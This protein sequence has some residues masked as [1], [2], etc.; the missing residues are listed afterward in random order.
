[1]TCTTA[2]APRSLGDWL[3]YQQQVH[4]AGIALGLERVAAVAARLGLDRPA[5][6]VITVAGTNGKGSTVAFIDAIARAAGY[7]VGAYTSPHL[8]RYNERIRIDGVE[9]DDATLIAAFETIEA[10]RGDTPLTYF[11]FG[12]LAALLLFERAGLDLAVLEVGL[13]GRLDAVNL[14]DADVAVVTTVALDH[15][16]WLG[17]DRESIGREKAGVFRPQRPAVIG[18]PVAPASVREHAARIAARPWQIGADFHCEPRFGGGFRYREGTLT[19]DLPA[20][21]LAARCQPGNACTAIAALRQLGDALP[22]ADAAWPVGVAGA[23]VAGRTQRVVHAG[24]EYVLD[25]AHNPQAAQQLAGWLR[26]EPSRGATQAVFAALA[27]KDIPHLVAAMQGAV[28]AWRLAGLAEVGRRGLAA[29][30]LWQ[31]VAGL[32]ARCL[33]SRHGSVTEA[34][35]HAEAQAVPGDRI[36]VFG[37]FHTVAAALDWLDQRGAAA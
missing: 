14:V 23:Q 28:D 27:D 19:L 22:I 3:D 18:E 9:V 36:V 13:G 30:A 21:A 15:M 31:Q 20:P 12:T 5:R 7:R 29:A 10:A 6:R 32:L 17:N 8:R 24:I 1:M 33:H 25:V 2:A 4:P 26:S 34:L 11:E 35:L 16:D 37:S